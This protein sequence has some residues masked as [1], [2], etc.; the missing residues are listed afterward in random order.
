MTDHDQRDQRRHLILQALADGPEQGLSADAL[1]QAGACPVRGVY[2]ELT[3]LARRGSIARV[4]DR[5]DARRRWYRLTDQGEKDLAQ[6]HPAVPAAHSH[7]A[8]SHD[9]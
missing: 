2:R 1:A 5:E 6:A 9:D 3:A 7:N 4:W 8:L